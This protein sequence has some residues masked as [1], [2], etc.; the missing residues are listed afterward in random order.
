MVEGGERW[1]VKGKGRDCSLEGK[2]SRVVNMWVLELD[3]RGSE[4]WSV[5]H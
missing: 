2:P 5:T 4:C 3:S 1:D